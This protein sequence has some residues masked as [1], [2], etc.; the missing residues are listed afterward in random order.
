MSNKDKI[1]L[2]ARFSPKTRTYWLVSG[3][4]VSVFTVVGIPL[5]L[6]WVPLAL[7][8]TGRFLDAMACILKS[9]ELIVRKGIFNRIEKTIPLEK[10]TDLGLQQ[11]PVMRYFGIHLLT[12][13]TAG[14]SSAGSLV[15]LTGIE[16]V[17]AFREAVLE[18][19]DK[20]TDREASPV[21]S[22]SGEADHSTESLLLEMRD[23]LH[24]IES[25]LKKD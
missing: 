16:D 18:Q 22:P 25:L 17:E 21:S 6:I 15:S 19:R 3:I 8:L 4:I 24:R 2:T 7:V 11:G 20:I 14:Q 5:M 1:L 12:V 10:I 13:E 9:R 23:T